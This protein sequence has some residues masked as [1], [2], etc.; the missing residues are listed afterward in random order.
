[1]FRVLGLGGFGFRGLRFRA[2]PDQLQNP[3][4]NPER[5]DKPFQTLGTREGPVSLIKDSF[6]TSI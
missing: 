5:L 3:S 1:M 2:R 6:L 4:T